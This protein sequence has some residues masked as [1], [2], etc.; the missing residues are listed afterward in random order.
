MMHRHSGQCQYI[1]F[2][3][4]TMELSEEARKVYEQ[5]QTY[6]ESLGEYPPMALR[7]VALGEGVLRRG[8]KE[9][10]EKGLWKMVAKRR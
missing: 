1:Y 2:S 10:E 5:Q 6:F 7:R 4:L 9:L 3:N 8:R